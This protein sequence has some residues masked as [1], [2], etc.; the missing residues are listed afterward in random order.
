MLHLFFGDFDL[1]VPPPHGR[2]YLVL[3]IAYNNASAGA[4]RS[5]SSEEKKKQSEEEYED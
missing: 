3:E 4:L 5:F 2:F 1:G